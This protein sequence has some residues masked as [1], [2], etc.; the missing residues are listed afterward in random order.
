M[1]V[2]TYRVSH[3]KHTMY[4]VTIAHTSITQHITE[5]LMYA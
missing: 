5:A 2:T 3:N 1:F 4:G